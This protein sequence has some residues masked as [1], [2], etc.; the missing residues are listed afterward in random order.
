MNLALLRADPT[1]GPCCSVEGSRMLKGPHVIWGN[2]AVQPAAAFFLSFRGFKNIF[3][4]IFLKL[5][6]TP[7]LNKI[8]KNANVLFNTQCRRSKQMP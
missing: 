8:A 4:M 2:Q 7:L 5:Q 3:S 6:K 1:S